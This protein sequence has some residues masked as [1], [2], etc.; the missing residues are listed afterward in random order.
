[1]IFVL[2]GTN[3]AG[4]SSVLGAMLRES[5]ADYYNP[6]EVARQLV[7]IQPHLSA[8]EANSKAWRKEIDMLNATIEDGGTFAFETTLGGRT[9]SRTLVD[10]AERGLDVRM[11]YVGLESPELHILRVQERVD[12]GGHDIPEAKIRERYESSRQN[13]IRL[14]PRLGALKVY[15]NS[16]RVGDSG[17]VEPRLLLHMEG[18]RIIF[19]AADVPAWARPIVDAA[20]GPGAANRE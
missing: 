8:T 20:S 4:K 19:A 9:V 2:A 12:R 10:A 18:G 5:G 14:L 16:V 11:W 17:V 1:M 6:D 7:T 13:L 15:D 3:G